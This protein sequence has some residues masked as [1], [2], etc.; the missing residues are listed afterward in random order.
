MLLEVPLMAQAGNDPELRKKVISRTFRRMLDFNTRQVFT[1]P[2]ENKR[3]HIMQA[4]KALQEGD[5]QRC[6][7]LIHSIKVWN[8]MPQE[9]AVKAMLAQKIQEEGLRTYLFTYA[10]FYST[11]SLSHLADTFDLPLSTAT[12]L[13]SKMI[14]N[15]ELAASLDQ[16]AGV[17]VLQSAELS[18]LQRLA[19]QLA[20]KASAMADASERY[21][22]QK[23]SNGEQR[24]DG[25]KG[26]RTEGQGNRER[27]G[28]TRGRGAPR[29]RGAAR[30]FEG[31][32]GR[33]VA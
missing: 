16:V 2:P 33:T 11:I 26:E 4:T 30:K 9:K 23:I 8:L 32:L 19:L 10:P 21:L 22:D 12:S 20:D 1:G 29:G 3:D 18:Q 15:E 31:G 27:R 7:D 13:V 28:A 6:V 24:A 14:W 5:W 17:V 25:I